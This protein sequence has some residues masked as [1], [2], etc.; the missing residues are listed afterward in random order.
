MCDKCACCH[1]V[2]YGACDTF[3]VGM[4]G[5]CVYCDHDESCHPGTGEYHNAPLAPVKRKHKKVAVAGATLARRK[6]QAQARQQAQ[7]VRRRKGER[8]RSRKR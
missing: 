8:Q 5:R 6:R 2:D 1:A 3:E 7:L 4:N